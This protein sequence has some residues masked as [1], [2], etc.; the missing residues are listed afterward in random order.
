MNSRLYCD[1]FPFVRA[2]VNIS[3][4]SVSWGISVLSA[5]LHGEAQK[6]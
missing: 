3:E 6:Q 1:R 4:D 2:F 5:A